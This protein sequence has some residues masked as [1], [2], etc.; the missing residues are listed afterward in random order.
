MRSADSTE[1]RTYLCTLESFM[2][3]TSGVHGG[4]IFH[5]KQTHTHTTCG[6]AHPSRLCNRAA[7][8][9]PTNGF[10]PGVGW[11]PAKTVRFWFYSYNI[12]CIICA[13]ISWQI[14]RH[15]DMR[16]SSHICDICKMF[17]STMHLYLSGHRRKHIWIYIIRE[18]ITWRYIRV[19]F[20][21]IHFV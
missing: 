1:C 14:R 20:T 4:V 17:I 15:A 18:R 8:T 19:F 2:S 11:P 7:L 5:A 9:I 13:A 16:T 6:H 10:W 3:M 21:M 12:V